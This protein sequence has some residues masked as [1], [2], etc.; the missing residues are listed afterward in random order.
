MGDNAGIL[1]LKSENPFPLMAPNS[2]PQVEHHDG[3]I[4]GFVAFA[5]VATKGAA[6]NTPSKSK[7]SHVYDICRIFNLENF[8]VPI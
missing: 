3:G 2:R 5:V 6:V 1:K 7:N 4:A 8:L